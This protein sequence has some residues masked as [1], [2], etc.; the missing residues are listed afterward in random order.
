MQEIDCYTDASYAK[1]VGGSVIGY[2]IGN[3][4]IQLLFLEGIKNTEAEVMAARRCVEETELLYPN[5]RINLHTD[6]Q[7][8][9]SQEF[10]YHV[11]LFKMKGHM[12]KKLMNN[13]QL[14][15]REV[16]KAARKTLRQRREEMI[17]PLT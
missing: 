10:A 9:M 16:D 1:D 13:K 5:R 14:V 3:N 12:K 17:T 6:C 7:E 15:F 11:R 2:K 8:V 4:P